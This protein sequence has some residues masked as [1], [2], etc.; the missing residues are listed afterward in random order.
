[1]S[2]MFKEIDDA[3]N[4]IQQRD[5]PDVAE[6]IRMMLDPLHHKMMG[7]TAVGPP[8]KTGKPVLVYADTRNLPIAIPSSFD[9]SLP[10]SLCLQVFEDQY[11]TQYI[12]HLRDQNN[13]GP[14]PGATA[15]NHGGVLITYFQG[16]GDFSWA[17]TYSPTC[18]LGP[19][20]GLTQFQSSVEGLAMATQVTM[21]NDTPPLNVGGPSHAARHNERSTDETTTYLYTN[22]P[23]GVAGVFQ[24]HEEF[25][26]PRNENQLAALPGYTQGLARDGAMTV[27]CCD[28]FADMSLPDFT[29][30]LYESGIPLNEPN[31][32]SVTAPLFRTSTQNPTSAV[33]VFRSCG[34]GVRPCQIRWVNVPPQTI[35]NVRIDRIFA[36]T[37]ASSIAAQLDTASLVRKATPRCS[38]AMNLLALL[39][40]YAPA[41]RPASDNK[42]FSWIKNAF[43]SAGPDIADI[44][45]GIPHPLA[46]AGSMALQ[47]LAPRQ[48]PGLIQ[49]INEGR[50]MNRMTRNP[51]PP[52]PPPMITNRRTYRQTAGRMQTN[53]TPAQPRNLFDTRNWAQTNAPRAV[54][55]VVQTNRAPKKKKKQARKSIMTNFPPGGYTI[56]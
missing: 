1:M 11:I 19:Q 38:R 20:D 23:A 45:G 21:Y 37:C 30:N 42:N 36:M 49:D 28:P 56:N 46:Q 52:P 44:L 40:R 26:Y 50:N 32:S 15:V 24:A 48:T 17:T 18:V 51:N 12:N 25:D 43:K 27:A 55:T 4:Y 53:P 14:T 29:H 33:P 5:G 3:I 35:G 9:Q 7:R 2:Y 22:G 54:R 8:S 34:S 16:A 39:L 47:F 31:T 10:F 41:M 6:W 13:I